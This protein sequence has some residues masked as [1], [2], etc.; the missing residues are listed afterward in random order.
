MR[1]IGKLYSA[2]HHSACIWDLGVSGEGVGY[3]RPNPSSLPQLYPSLPSP[4]ALPPSCLVTCS[5]DNT[6]RF[7]AMDMSSTTGSSLVK[8]IYSKDLVRIIY[9]SSDFSSLND[10]SKYPGRWGLSLVEYCW[11]GRLLPTSL[12]RC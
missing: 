8:N 3:G 1:Q 6:I 11:L 5:T 12:R 10:T 7:W 9:A 4:G 2:L